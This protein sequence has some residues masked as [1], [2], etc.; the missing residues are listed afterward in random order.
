MGSGKLVEERFPYQLH[1]T[2]VENQLEAIELGVLNGCIIHHSGGWL[3]LL[4]MGE[5]GKKLE[6]YVLKHV[7]EV[8][9]SHNTL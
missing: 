4:L 7:N 5:R 2:R 3:D 6:N 9:R 1:Q 8:A